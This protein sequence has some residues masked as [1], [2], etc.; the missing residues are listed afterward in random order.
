MKKSYQQIFS[1]AASIH[2]MQAFYYYKDALLS[3]VKFI[4]MNAIIR[5]QILVV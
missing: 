3:L 4:H 2:S 5:K 1:E